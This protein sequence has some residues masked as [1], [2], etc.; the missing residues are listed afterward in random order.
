MTKLFLVILLII[1]HKLMMIIITTFP[2]NSDLLLK[3]LL[4]DEKRV[5]VATAAASTAKGVQI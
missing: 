4:T 1:H 3:F 5:P 2:I